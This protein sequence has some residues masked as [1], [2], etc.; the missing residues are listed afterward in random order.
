MFRI[1]LII[2]LCL[3]WIP[4]V[5]E[6]GFQQQPKNIRKIIV[7]ADYDYAP[8]TY[9]DKEGHAKGHDVD[10]I[11]QVASLM[12]LEVEFKLTPWDEALQNLKEGR[13][14]VLISIL[15]TSARNQIF[16]F[17]IPYNTDHYVIF[18]RSD[19]DITGVAD[20]QNRKLIAL[21]NDA[22]VD[23]FIKPLGLQEKTTFSLSLPEAIKI[24]DSGRRDYVLA[25]YSIGMNTIRG[26]ADSGKINESG[27]IKMV[28]HPVLPVLYR[29]GVKKGNTDLL[30][31]LNDGLDKLKSSGRLLEIHDQWDMDHLE[32]AS[33]EKLIRN[34]AIVL[35][36][37]LLV[38]LALLLWSRT[39]KREVLKKSE[40]LRQSMAEAEKANQAKSQFLANMSHEIRTPLNA[41]LGFSQIL[42][43]DY[44]NLD[45]PDRFKRFLK[46]IRTSGEQLSELVN[47]ILDISKIEAGKSEV[48]LEDVN[49]KQLVRDICEVNKSESQRKG[50]KFEYQLD[51]SIPDYV[52]SDQNKA[53]QIL[54]NLVRN[55]VKFTPSGKSV[56][57]E[58]QKA[59]NCLI[60]IV[61]DKG[62]GI[63]QEYQEK[64]FKP[65]EQVDNS[66]TRQYE[67]TGLGLAIARENVRI[68]GGELTLES[69]KDKGSRFVVSLPLVV[70]RKTMMD[71]TSPTLNHQKFSAE[72]RIL[73]IED[74]PMTQNY[75]SALLES[76]GMQIE[77]AGSG[78]LG[79]EKALEWKPDLILMDVRLPDIDGLTATRNILCH[80]AGEGIPIVILSADVLNSQQ[81]AAREA[82]A[83]DYLTKPLQ[84]K[85]LQKVMD[86][87]LT[88][89]T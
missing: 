21:K 14:D 80:P 34:V 51:Q 56:R 4:A 47:N 89:E 60:I 70:S 28:G 33:P 16:D 3:F 9:L 7:G 6:T 75:L 26:L 36:C 12:G 1:N 88:L 29:L 72:N 64:I 77:I 15:Y 39:L 71:R 53:K 78:Q 20:L 22:V 83:R 73:V 45:L 19:S 81:E 79:I 76:F 27:K 85:A 17:S 52:K 41:I 43:K 67:G 13:V 32:E 65:F 57:V 5:A 46:N 63:P 11:L 40:K 18:V 30:I 54:S 62:I 25:P 84:I 37:L 2:V 58:T 24:L 68:L 86:T 61:E 31:L 10:I 66:N 55:A 69:E 23:K 42:V 44:Q 87:Y 8:Y 38:I 50:I 35:I 49:F 74:N 48:Q 82:G 59:G